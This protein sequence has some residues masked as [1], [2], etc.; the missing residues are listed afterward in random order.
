MG[1][2]LKTWKERIYKFIMLSVWI[3]KS[4]QSTRNRGQPPAIEFPYI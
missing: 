4:L 2:L 1:S 3:E